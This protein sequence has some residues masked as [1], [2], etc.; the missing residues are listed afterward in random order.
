MQQQH[1]MHKTHNTKF[2]TIVSVF[3]KYSAT[4]GDIHKY[5]LKDQR[6]RFFQS[7]RLVK[8]AE[9]SAPDHFSLHHLLSIPDI[10]PVLGLCIEATALEV[11]DRNMN[12]GNLGLYDVVHFRY[13]HLEGSIS[14][15]NV[16]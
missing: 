3:Y 2:F 14:V 7:L 16:R 6:G 1:R 13:F 12:V 8:A 15:H 10:H 11:E 5:I 4:T 9:P